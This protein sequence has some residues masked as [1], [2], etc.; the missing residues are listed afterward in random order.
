MQLINTLKETLE[1]PANDHSVDDETQ[2]RIM[3]SS[4]DYDSQISKDEDVDM[5]TTILP[6]LDSTSFNPG[7]KSHWQWLVEDIRKNEFGL[8]IGLEEDG[9]KLLE[10]QQDRLGRSLE[11][12]SVDLYSR[13]AHFLLELVQNADDNQYNCIG[14]VHESRINNNYKWSHVTFLNYR[15][16]SVI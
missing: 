15:M 10:K 16:L 14:W 12:L 9:K 8:G 6:Q 11:R 5:E 3:T 2:M 4:T 13:D 7:M 1:L